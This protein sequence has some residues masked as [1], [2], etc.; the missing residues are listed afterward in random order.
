MP[1]IDLS[2]LK[3]QA[4]R[5]SEY[6][7]QPAAYVRALLE[8][9]DFY[10]N[11]TMRASQVAR[12]LSLPTYHT[13]VPVLRQVERELAPLADARPLESAALV[14][15][16]WNSAS[17][18]TRL[19]AARLLG[20]TPPAAVMP[21]LSHLPDWLAQSTDKQVREALLTDAFSRVRTEAPE[22]FFILLEEWLNSPRSALQ[23]W[24]LQA[25]I[26]LLKQPDFENLPAV[27]R[28]LRPAVLAAG[29]S[30]QLELQ[31]CLAAVEKISRTETLV[32]LRG[33]LADRPTP[34]FLR[35]LRR[36]LPGF[37][38]ELQNGLREM[39]REKG[40]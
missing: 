11:R 34:G 24:G 36:M 23:V 7:S 37:S 10:T 35:T 25:L 17:L 33:L 14:P 20:M 8:L 19:L 29:P 2:R 18:E 28:I 16:L 1:A 4:G 6:F 31:A 9:L 5:L 38:P 26:P 13:P 3:L 15:A 22:A 12:R 32:F 39:L 27:L 30:T 21:L 40:L